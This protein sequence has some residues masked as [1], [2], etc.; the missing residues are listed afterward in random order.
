[1]DQFEGINFIWTRVCFGGS[2][3]VKMGA[4]WFKAFGPIWFGPVL[5][6]PKCSM[7]VLVGKDES[8]RVNKNLT[9]I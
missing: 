2:K 8:M 3:V 7:V 1:M 4:S 5:V 6:G 9:P